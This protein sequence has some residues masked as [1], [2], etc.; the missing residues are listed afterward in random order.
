M[1]VTAVC[2]HVGEDETWEEVFDIPGDGES[3]QAIIDRF[4]RTLK[5]G[6]RA[7]ELVS[8]KDT[9]SITKEEVKEKLLKALDI[10]EEDYHEDATIGEF[11]DEDD[12]DEIIEKV[13]ETFNVNLEDQLTLDTPIEE[14]LDGLNDYFGL[15]PESREA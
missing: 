8:C 5:P 2:K 9:P 11:I 6:E 14:L 3:A 13:G 1:K 4:N 15:K 7:R 10:A 12:L